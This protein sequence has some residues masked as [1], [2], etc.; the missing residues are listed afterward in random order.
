MALALTCAVHAAGR[1]NRAEAQ[2]VRHVAEGTVE[3]VFRP[4][5][6]KDA[7]GSA[8]VQGNRVLNFTVAAFSFAAAIA[9][10]LHVV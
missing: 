10:A 6:S 2:V 5:G 3:H 7:A 1:S 8:A 9:A 4:A